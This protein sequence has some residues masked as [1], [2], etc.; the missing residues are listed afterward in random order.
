MGIFPLKYRYSI[1]K[2]TAYDDKKLNS[3]LQAARWYA[4][5]IHH[6]DIEIELAKEDLE[7]IL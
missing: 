2:S 5:Y 1:L 3:L 6:S 7:I 4:Q